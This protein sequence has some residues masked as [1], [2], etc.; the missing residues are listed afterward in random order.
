VDYKDLNYLLWDP[1]RHIWRW[2]WGFNFVDYAYFARYWLEPVDYKWRDERADLNGDGVV[3]FGDFAMFANEWQ[4][5]PTAGD[6]SFD[7]DP[8][9]LSGYVTMSIPD[10]E[11]NTYRVFALLDGKLH[12]EFFIEM[13]SPF[14]GIHSERFAN[15]PHSIKI[16]SI[17]IYGSVICSQTNQVI[18]NNELSSVTMSEFYELDEPYCLYAFGS[19]EANY[20]GLFW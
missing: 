17:D 1:L 2:P 18:F 20:T 15:G 16:A 10:P 9:N 19:P 14:V 4:P 11:P 12:R 7:G 6:I 5:G 13:E 3:N 8:N